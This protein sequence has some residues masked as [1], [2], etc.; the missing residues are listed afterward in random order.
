MAGHGS[1][2]YWRVDG[3]LAK[4]V[5]TQLGILVVPPQQR[6]LDSL[7]LARSCLR[8]DRATALSRVYKH[9]RRI[10]ESHFEHEER[11]SFS[12]VCCAWSNGSSCVPATCS[13]VCPVLQ[14]DRLHLLTTRRRLFVSSSK[15]TTP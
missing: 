13:S 9:S 7:G 11:L 8:A 14:T 3:G 10:E 4:E 5:Q 1:H 6:A 2:G 15:A 12:G